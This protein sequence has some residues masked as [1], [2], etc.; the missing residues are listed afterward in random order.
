MSVGMHTIRARHSV[1]EYTGEPIELDTLEQLAKIV[2]ETARE[3]GLNIQLIC[4]N[5][6]VF[7]VVAKLGIIRGCQ[8]HIAFVVREGENVDERIGYWGQKIVLE[9]QELGLNT[10]WVGICSRKKSRAARKLGEKIRLVIAVGYGKT[11]GKERKT[12]SVSELAT[13]KHQP[14]P[15][16][17]ETAMEAA[18]LAPTAVNHQN[19]R[20]TLNADGET[21]G[22]KAPEGGFNQVDL[23]IVKRNF[24]VA[25]NEADTDWTWG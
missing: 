20:I 11:Q 13:I 8:T 4:D 17:F 9:A 23:G 7:Q 21:V 15:A 3:S 16:W 25:A 5:P 14:A 10:C 2:G 1:R 18:Q 19:F 12:K 6:E 24:E 22:A